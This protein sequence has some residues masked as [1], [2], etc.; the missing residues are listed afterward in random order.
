MVS[1]NFQWNFHL[2]V[3]QDFHPVE[4]LLDVAALNEQFG[5]NRFLRGEVL[6]IPQVHKREMLFEYVGK[7]ALGKSS[8]QGHLPAFKPGAHPRPSPRALPF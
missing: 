6:E 2:S 7:A 8:M 3:T 5:S 1:H 4:Y